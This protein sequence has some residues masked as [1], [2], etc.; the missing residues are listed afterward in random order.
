LRS[1]L[2]P[3]SAALRLVSRV[4]RPLARFGHDAVI[5]SGIRS[6]LDHAQDGRGDVGPPPLA[7]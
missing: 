5:S 3:A 7:S 4:A 6:F 2:A 1:E